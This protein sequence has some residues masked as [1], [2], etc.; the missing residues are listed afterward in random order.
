MG[1]ESKIRKIKKLIFDRDNN[2]LERFK[3]LRLVSS[4]LLPEYQF[5]WPFLDW[6]N[7]D[8][9]N[10]YLEKIGERKNNNADRRWMVSQLI[11]LTTSLKGH[12]AEVGAFK[13][14]M[15][16]IICESN[17][18]CKE[19]KHHYIFDS[20]EGLSEP[21]ELDGNFWTN[22]DMKSSEST[23]NKNLKDLC[24]SVNSKY[25][26]YHSLMKDKRDGLKDEFTYWRDDF[27]GYDGVHPNKKG[28]LKMEKIISK[29]LKK[30]L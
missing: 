6:W 11:L 20:F 27:N 16:L 8:K 22:N 26:D 23:L 9:F 29:T 4:I 10:L 15:S 30:I 19:K 25:V 3:L 24:K 7:N 18:K 5:K 2:I 13:G 12:T 14:A 1:I 21:C 28:Y 17:S